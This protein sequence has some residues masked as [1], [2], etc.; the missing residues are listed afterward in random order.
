[1]VDYS[2]SIN[3]RL[4]ERL[5]SNRFLNRLAS[6]DIPSQAA[7]HILR[8]LLF[9]AEQN[10]RFGRINDEHDRDRVNARVMNIGGHHFVQGLVVRLA[11]LVLA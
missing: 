7:K 8:K 3:A 4:L 2:I 10:V 5:S 1:M 6:F 11:L 9:P